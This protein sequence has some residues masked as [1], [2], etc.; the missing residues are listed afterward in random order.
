[1]T[2][3]SA[4]RSTQRR[5][6]AARMAAIRSEGERYAASMT[7]P[8]C[9]GRLTHNNSLADTV[10]LQCLTPRSLT[11]GTGC[12]WQFCYGRPS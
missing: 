12:G 1:M 8:A 9:G 6:H 3:L 2:A 5:E 4:T 10:W 11:P 7:C